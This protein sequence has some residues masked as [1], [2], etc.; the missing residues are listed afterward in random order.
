LSR[1]DVKLL[2]TNATKSVVFAPAPD[3]ERARGRKLDIAKP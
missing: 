1:H 2:Y 3:F